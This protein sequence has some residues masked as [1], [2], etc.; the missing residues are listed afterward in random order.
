MMFVTK[1]RL[2]CLVK[3]DDNLQVGMNMGVL[4]PNIL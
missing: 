2:K 4:V 3:I 1:R